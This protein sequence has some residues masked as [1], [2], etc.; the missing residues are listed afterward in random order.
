[1]QFL[2]ADAF[3]P[4]FIYSSVFK[5][6]TL[7]NM[8]NRGNY[9]IDVK[10]INGRYKQIKFIIDYNYTL[11]FRVEGVLNNGY[12][13]NILKGGGINTEPTGRSDYYGVNA[14]SFYR[15]LDY[16]IK[17]VSYA[18]A[19]KLNEEVFPVEIVKRKI[20]TL[21]GSTKF[22]DEFIKAQEEFTLKGYIVLTVGL[23]GHAD[24]KYDNVI[25]PEVKTMLD[26]LHKDK[27]SMSD[28][29]YVINKDGYIGESTK[30]EIEHA[31]K[32]GKEISYME[33]LREDNNLGT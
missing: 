11:S 33:S 29:I 8:Y 14:E 6:D 20:I 28:G 9:Q 15:Q 10:I 26:Q 16:T 12:I 13:N 31:K 32:L 22:K 27:I 5:K 30:S 1:M 17:D 2:V 3:T 24:H 23:F 4:D 25:T 18:M 7:N 19:N 21:C